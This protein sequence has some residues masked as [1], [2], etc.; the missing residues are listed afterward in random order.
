LIKQPNVLV[1]KTEDEKI[2]YGS[3]KG[4]FGELAA[5]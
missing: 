5:F 1:L 4:M 3:E 2:G